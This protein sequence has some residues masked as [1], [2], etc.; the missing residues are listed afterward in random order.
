[1]RLRRS[2]GLTL[3]AAFF[4]F[5]A[6]MASL[7]FVGL[8]LPGGALDAIW[9][10]NP[11]ARVALT[12]LGVWGIVLMLAVAI[13]CAFASVGIWVRTSWGRRLAIGILAVNLLGDLLNAVVGG[14]LRTLI[15][16]PIGGALILY[17]LS[18]R[19]RAQFELRSAAV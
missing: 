2:L 11:R 3:L 12:E 1:M 14:D 16:I 7:S 18:S 13:A 15:G 9:Q 17:L 19:T 6:L 8:L 4:L 10:F 5:G